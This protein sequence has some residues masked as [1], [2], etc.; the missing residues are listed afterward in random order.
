MITGSFED[1]HIQALALPP[2]ED[3][4]EFAARYEK[5]SNTGSLP[6]DSPEAKK[7]S[8]AIRRRQKLSTSWMNDRNGVLLQSLMDYT[9]R[10]IRLNHLLDK[11]LDRVVVPLWDDC[12]QARNGVRVRIDNFYYD[13]HSGETIVVLEIAVDWMNQYGPQ[14]DR[15]FFSGRHV[16]PFNATMNA[17]MKCA[18]TYPQLGL[19]PLQVT[20]CWVDKAGH[21]GGTQD[22]VHAVLRLYDSTTDLFWVGAACDADVLRATSLAIIRAV[23]WTGLLSERPNDPL[24]QYLVFGGDFSL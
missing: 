18:A 16:S 21:W 24:R 23:Q 11:H 5:I 4:D 19:R 6:T 1:F 22:R 2:R 12:G 13:E 10:M 3:W 20:G 8:R 14:N 15:E 17:L 7:L 9:D